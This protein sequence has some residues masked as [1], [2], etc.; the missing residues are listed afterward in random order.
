[1][2]PTDPGGRRSDAHRLPRRTVLVHAS[3]LADRSAAL[4]RDGFVL[5][6]DA[7]DAVG[8]AAIVA[9]VDRVAHDE[10]AA[11]RA[12]PDGSVH[13]L[14]VIDRDPLLAE[15]LVTP[16]VLALVCTTLGWNIHLYHS[17]VDVHPPLPAP[18]RPVWRWHQ[19]GG[20]QN[21]DLGG[22]ELRPRLSVKVAYFLSD[23]SEPGRGN[24]LV[25]PG[26]HRR[27]VLPRPERPELGFAE[28]DG[29]V[30]IL[31]APGTA[32]VFDRR[33]WH[34]R[35]PNVSALTRKAVFTGY[36]Y[37][38]IRPRHEH[39]PDIHPGLDAVQRQLLGGCGSRLG[40]WIPA[41]ADVPLR[42]WMGERGLLDPANPAHR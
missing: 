10:A 31:A 9:V 29:H 14:E 13:A 42:T 36:T 8:V 27:N 41:D 15:L 5:I 17:H 20:R 30:P 34:G 16:A 3:D 35:S 18:P 23:V 7:L 21:L 6:P 33:I 24:M 26:S 11:G 37:R 25:I 2:Q 12:G 32:C 28:P 1:M 4:E 22:P 38:W 40:Y 39:A 19:D